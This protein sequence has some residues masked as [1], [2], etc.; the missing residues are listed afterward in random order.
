MPHPPIHAYIY[1][2]KVD[3]HIRSLNMNANL[4]SPLYQERF[5]V[6]SLVELIVLLIPGIL[7]NLFV[8]LMIL[9]ESSFPK[10][11]RLLMLNLLAANITVG[12]SGV[13]LNTAD[14]IISA[15]NL[16]VKPSEHFC[17]IFTCCL[18]YTSDAADE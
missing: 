7:L 5:R 4:S 1:V 13:I 6:G 15:T 3:L 14:V 10:P 9:R 2:Y 16:Y 18:L 8:Q 12:L 17:H 11:V